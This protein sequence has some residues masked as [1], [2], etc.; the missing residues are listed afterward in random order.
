M[1]PRSETSRRRAFPSL[2]L[3]GGVSPL[4]FA[5]Y[6]ASQLLFSSGYNVDVLAGCDPFIQVL[7]VEP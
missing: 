1:Y 5:Q 4:Q 6:Q 2:L 7:N 3:A